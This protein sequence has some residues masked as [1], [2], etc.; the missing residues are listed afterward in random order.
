MMKALAAVADVVVLLVEGMVASWMIDP[1]LK[2]SN[3]TLIL[4]YGRL[5]SEMFYQRT[6]N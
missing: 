3:E 6:N 2:R 1:M 5:M 4:F